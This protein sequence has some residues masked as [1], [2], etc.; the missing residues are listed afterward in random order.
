MGR[1]E[2]LVN[3]FPLW[4]ST[5]TVNSHATTQSTKLWRAYRFCIFMQLYEKHFPTRL[6]SVVKTK[7][8]P[9]FSNLHNYLQQ[10]WLGLIAVCVTFSV[11]YVASVSWGLLVFVYVQFFEIPLT[12]DRLDFEWVTETTWFLSFS[13]IP[14]MCFFST[15]D[16]C[17]VAWTTKLYV[18]SHLTFEY[19]DIEKISWWTQWQ[20]LENP[21]PCWQLLLYYIIVFILYIMAKHLHFGLNY[22][23]YIL[24]QSFFNCNVMNFGLYCPPLAC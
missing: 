13:V 14:L 7:H 19:F 5:Q 15:L 12:P 6:Q 24:V 3:V 17:S 8:T 4:L 11:S 2:V 10:Q 22:L 23:I 1:Y 18:A 9:W 21:P 20:W 16:H